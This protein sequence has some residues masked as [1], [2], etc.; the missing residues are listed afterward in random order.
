MAKKPKRPEKP[1]VMPM[2]PLVVSKRPETTVVM[3]MKP[4]VTSKAQRPRQESSLPKHTIDTQ[5][6]NEIPCSQMTSRRPQQKQVEQN[7]IIT[8][9]ILE[10]SIYHHSMYFI[11]TLNYTSREPQ[12]HYIYH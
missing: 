10:H 3:P 6:R 1:V 12:E 11:I 2:K 8:P 9:F 7:A 5:Q 4:L